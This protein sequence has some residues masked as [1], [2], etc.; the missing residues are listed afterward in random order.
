M[1]FLTAEEFQTFCNDLGTGFLKERKAHFMLV[2]LHDIPAIVKDQARLLSYLDNC[3][4][5]EGFSAH[6]IAQIQPWLTEKFK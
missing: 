5:M 4:A 6:A 2:T 3:L 1:N